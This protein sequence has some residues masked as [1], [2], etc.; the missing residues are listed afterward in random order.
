MLTALWMMIL[1]IRVSI[2][3]AN[4]MLCRCYLE[5]LLAANDMPSHHSLVPL[6][7]LAFSFVKRKCGGKKTVLFNCI[8]FLVCVWRLIVHFI[9][10]WQ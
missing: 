6:K 4:D 2:L 1:T 9:D 5:S 7:S 3:A 10:L 8:M